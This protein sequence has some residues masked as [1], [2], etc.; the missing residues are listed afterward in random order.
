MKYLLINHVPLGAGDA[1]GTVRIGDLFL[2][3]IAAQAKS[4]REIGGE[5]TLATPL[6]DRLSSRASGSF[7]TL[8][9]TPQEYGFSYE[10][11]PGYHS[12]RSFLSVRRA[13]LARVRELVQH[14]DVIQLDYGG[15]PFSLGQVLWPVV[16]KASAGKRVVWVFDGG[17]PFPQWEFAA[18]QARNPLK[19]QLKLGALRRFET[20][21]RRRAIP[22]ADIVFAHNNSVVRRFQDVWN[23]HCHRF[24]RTFVTDEILLTP[25]QLLVKQKLLRSDNSVLR[26]V[27]AGRQIAIKG[28]DHALRAMAIARERHHIPLELDIYGDGEQHADYETLAREL[29]LADSVRFRGSVPYGPQLFE[30]WRDKHVLILTNLTSEFSRNIILGMARGLPLVTYDNP[31]DALVAPN[32]AGLIAPM[33]NV[34][35]LAQRM[36]EA[37]RDREKLATLAQ[38]GWDL[39]RQRTLDACHRQRAQLVAQVFGG[40]LHPRTVRRVVPAA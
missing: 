13:L 10:P 21:L 17:D 18:R 27:I 19:R 33:G 40:D 4:I 5:L 7:N 22:R 36:A 20:F 6:V 37:H 39:A 26:M 16:E 14:A 11:L 3:D 32:D 12:L 31:A 38:I 24:D 1:P 2:Q 9:I 34:E 35:Q 8:E 23:E 15:H 25:E 28:T 29:H 30:T